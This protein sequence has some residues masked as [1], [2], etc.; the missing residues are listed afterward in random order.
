[1]LQ[2][3]KSKISELYRINDEL[4][5]NIRIIIRNHEHNQNAFTEAR[6]LERQM[7]DNK[8]RIDIYLEIINLL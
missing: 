2:L 5:S 4:Y 8:I 7:E 3:L 1:M 6:K